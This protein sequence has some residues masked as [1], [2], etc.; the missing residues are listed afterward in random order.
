MLD[1]QAV[2][3]FVL[4]NMRRTGDPLAAAGDEL[5]SWAAGL[6]VPSPP[7]DV[8]LYTGHLYQLVP[9]M[10]AS[11]TALQALESSP[12]SGLVV[13]A[14]RLASR[15]LSLVPDGGLASRVRRILS[16]AYSLLRA[17]GYDASY[18]GPSEPYSGILLYDLGLL[19]EFRE[20]AGR[21]L[22]FLER[23]R[24]GLV[25]TL[26]PHTTYALRSL[27]PRYAGKP[28]EVKHI[29]E[30]V[31]P[32]AAR[33]AGEPGDV[34]VHDSCILSRELNLH[35]RLREVLSA[36]GYRVHEPE[37]SGPRTFCCGGP[38]ASLFPKVA[39]EIARRRAAQL[40]G[41]PGPVASA[42]PVCLAYLGHFAEV[43]DWLELVEA[44]R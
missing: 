43:L 12:I 21:V 22:E 9:R 1:R 5:S 37:R 19:D 17:S 10:R 28:P 42:C 7:S 36:A 30:L 38:L 41:L 25:V 20:Q 16:N 31:D 8:L 18:A 23:S 26:D 15:A 39:A 13:R 40:S 35:G 11:L 32:S 4:G 34:K 2:V 29:L 3:D 24:A 14:G 44:G 6:G 27:Y 33:P